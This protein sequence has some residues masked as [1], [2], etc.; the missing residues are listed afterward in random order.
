LKEVIVK[1]VLQEKEDGYW[2]HFDADN[3]HVMINVENTFNR[4]RGI[5]HNTIRKWARSQFITEKE[6]V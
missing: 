4:S 5:V 1:L 6:K 3:K 2:L